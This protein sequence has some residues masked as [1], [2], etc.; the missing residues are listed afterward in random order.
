MPYVRL[1]LRDGA[2]GVTAGVPVSF[3]RKVMWFLL[4]PIRADNLPGTALQL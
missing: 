2:D 1:E 4:D 3:L